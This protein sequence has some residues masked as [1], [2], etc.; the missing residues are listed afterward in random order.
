[1]RLAVKAFA[2]VLLVAVTGAYA[3]EDREARDDTPSSSREALDALRPTGPVTVKADR[4]EW[5]QDNMMKYAGR[6]SMVSNTLSVLGDSMDIKQAADGQFEA[7]VRGNPAKLDHAADAKASGVAAQPVH[8][9]AR[10]IH[11]DSRSGTVNMTGNAILKRGSDI[12]DGNTI[13]YIVPERRI[14][15]AGGGNGQVTITFQPPPKKS[16]SQDQQP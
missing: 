14:R 10:E 7:W 6:V 4:V 15:A 16:D 3:Q 13:G 11:Y 5:V 1:M 12:V 9:E 2:A 8:A